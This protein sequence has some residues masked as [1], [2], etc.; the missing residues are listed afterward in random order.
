MKFK[1]Y[2]LT[3]SGP[4]YSFSKTVSQARQKQLV[5]PLIYIVD[6]KDIYIKLT[7]AKKSSVT[8]NIVIINKKHQS[9]FGV[10]CTFI[11]E[12]SKSMSKELKNV[13][14]F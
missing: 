8:R 5:V 13:A 12:F 1:G 11:E 2:F 9:W 7:N 6:M 4:E 14:P 3:S 10:L